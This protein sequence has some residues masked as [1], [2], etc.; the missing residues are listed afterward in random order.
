MASQE[1]PKP[2]LTARELFY[3]AASQPAPAAQ[4]PPKP[5]PKKATAAPAQKATGNQPRQPVMT[6]P[7]I[8][9][10]RLPLDG[11][12]IQPVSTAPSTAPAPATGTAL[13]LKY[14]IL[15]RS[16]NDMVEVPPDTVFHAGDRIQFS[17]QTN[18]P[19]YLYIVGQGSSGTWKPM[20]PSSEV[21]DGNN[22]VDGWHAYTMPPKSRMVFDEQT[23]V[24]KIFIVF[25]REPETDLENMIYSLQ[26]DKPHPATQDGSKPKQ[27]V[28]KAGLNIDD[29]TV[30]RLR[31]TYSRDL[32]IE[33]VDDKTPADKSDKQENAVYVVNP[34]GSSSSRVV[35]DLKLV[36]Q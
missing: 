9:V 20:F 12:P 5:P 14:T 35:A 25:S 10:G 28:Q 8:V 7:H 22:H 17:V 21:E 13:G 3:S 19:G 2:Q 29:S 33:R 26:G 18:G 34:S 15:R 11:S 6:P 4:T 27:L 23:G 30:G 31:S 36:H 1:A 24:E 16:G 32:I